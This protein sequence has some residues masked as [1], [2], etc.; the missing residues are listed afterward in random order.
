[1][2]QYVD[3]VDSAVIEN[4]FSMI[5][6]RRIKSRFFVQGSKA[7]ETAL[8]LKRAKPVLRIKACGAFSIIKV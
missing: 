6:S 7:L 2:F 4:R 1:M 3:K 5:L 8:F